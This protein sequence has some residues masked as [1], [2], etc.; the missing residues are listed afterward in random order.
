MKSSTFKQGPRVLVVDDHEISRLHIV[1][2]LRQIT[3]DVK[4]AGNER[5]AIESA[6]SQLPELIFMDLHLPGTCGISLLNLIRKSWP[7][8]HQWPEIVMLTG[9]CSPQSMQQMRNAPV[10]AILI[11]PVLANDI[12]DASVRLL[13]LDQGVREKTADDAGDIPLVKLRKM[14]QQE[15]QTRLP[16]LDRNICDLDWASAR[17]ILHQLTAASAMC[18]EKDFERHCRNLFD[19]L[20]ESPEAGTISHTYY[21]FLK[22]MGRIGIPLQA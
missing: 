14:F 20:A 3:G 16:E 2:A 11:K 7:S 18:D 12:R 6:L 21:P 8:G 5:E 19:V 4:Q 10:S 17:G 22:S 13:Q 15:L 9:D 1:Q